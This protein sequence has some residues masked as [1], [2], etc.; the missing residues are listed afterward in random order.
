MTFKVAI[1]GAGPA[2]LVCARLLKIADIGIDVNI[3]ERDATPTARVFRGG[4]LDLHGDSGLVAIKK[5]GLF[6]EAQKWLRWDGEEIFVAD[7]NGTIV[8]HLKDPPKNDLADYER[9]EIDRELLK[10]LLLNGV[11]K[12]NVHW[13]KVLQSVNTRDKTITFRDGTTA[14]PFDLTIGADGAFSKVREVLTDVKPVYSGVCG[15]EAYVTEPD[16]KHPTLI[17]RVGGGSL[18][19][20]CDQ[21]GIVAQRVFDRSLKLDIFWKTDDENFTTDMFA[22]YSANEDNLKAHMLKTFS[23]WLPEMQEFISACH[24]LRPSRLY[25]LPVG[26]TWEHKSGFTLIGDAA[27]L[28]TPFS[29]EGANKALTDGLTLSEAL[30]DAL[31]RKVNPEEAISAFEQAMF[32]RAEKLQARTMLNKT[33]I[34]GNWGAAWWPVTI[35]SFVLEDMGYDFHK[36]WL[37]L[38]PLLKFAFIYFQAVQILGGV[39]RRMKHAISGW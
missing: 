31:K 13:G 24:I 15:F 38:L 22:A 4:S 23:D 30:V 25:E 33:R 7:K 37:S 20:F 29:G 12:E 2:G 17:K 3:F 10:E 26:N 8:F 19:A 9:P 14:G 28:M 34:F 16:E 35:G 6:E 32:R 5:A 36:G 27:N 39:K 1:I 21:K 11:G 18:F